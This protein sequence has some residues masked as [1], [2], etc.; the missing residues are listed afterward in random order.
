LSRVHRTLP[1]FL[2][3]LSAEFAGYFLPSAIAAEIFRLTALKIELGLAVAFLVEVMP[4]LRGI[5]GVDL[6]LKGVKLFENDQQIGWVRLL[7]AWHGIEIFIERAGQARKS[8][9]L[10]CGEVHDAA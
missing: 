9:G 8:F 1:D 5:S 4:K 3:K 7:L 6:A 2:A 10:V